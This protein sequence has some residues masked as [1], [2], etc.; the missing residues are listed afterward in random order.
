M[1]TSFRTKGGQA[2]ATLSVHPAVRS[3]NPLGEVPASP[4]GAANGAL[5]KL[6]DSDHPDFSW[7]ALTREMEQ[8]IAQY[9]TKEMGNCLDQL[10][11][12]EFLMRDT[13]A[14][15]ACAD[16]LKRPSYMK[17]LIVASRG[18]VVPNQDACRKCKMDDVG[19]TK[20]TRFGQCYR[21][22]G[23]FGSACAHCVWQDKGATECEKYGPA[24]RSTGNPRA[25][26]RIPL[27]DWSDANPYPTNPTDKL[28]RTFTSY[29]G[30]IALDGYH[31]QDLEDFDQAAED[32]LLGG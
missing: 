4:P 20:L 29:R 31:Q 22:P 12:Q 1:L 30:E 3:S 9:G 6:R 2:V 23:W 25:A 32:Q 27:P 28:F 13:A 10:A 16:I 21:L 18:E 5:F 8:L 7:Y 14:R 17:G 19:R 11:R 15:M 24:T 26:T